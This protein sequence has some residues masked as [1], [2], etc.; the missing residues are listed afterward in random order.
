M[1]NDTIVGGLGPNASQVGGGG[2][3]SS[4]IRISSTDS[5]QQIP[6]RNC[7]AGAFDCLD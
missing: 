1:E 2:L 5:V 7:R 6:Y 3:S 4:G